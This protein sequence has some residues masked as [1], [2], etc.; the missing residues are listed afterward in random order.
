MNANDM[1]PSKYIKAS[2]L[3][4]SKPVVKI[5]RIAVEQLGNDEEGKD[6]K[7]VVYFEG[8]EKG[9]VCNK[10]NWSTIVNLYGNETDNWIGKPIRLQTAE[11]AF[12]GKMTM[13]IRVSLIKPESKPTPKN[14]FANEFEDLPE[15]T[16]L[17]DEIKDEAIQEDPDEMP[18]R[19]Q[20]CVCH[21]KSSVQ[22]KKIGTLTDEV[23]MRMYNNFKMPVKHTNADLYLKSAL[24]QWHKEYSDKMKE[25]AV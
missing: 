15:G 14:E 25:Q 11:V 2:D 16:T 21:I 6:S 7:P 24:V 19:W 13:A 23:L 10:T 4:D 22:G 18:A 3:G 20:D 17:V 12:K 9:L 8:K 1:F 5:A